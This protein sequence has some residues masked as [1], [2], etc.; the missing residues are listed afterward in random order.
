[1]IHLENFNFQQTES[2]R[3]FSCRVKSSS[4]MPERLTFKAEGKQLL[5]DANPKVDYAAV[6]LLYPAMAFG[7]DIKI[8]GP[9][10]PTLLYQ[11]NHDIQSL[12]IAYQPSLKR[13]S[14]QAS[15]ADIQSANEQPFVATGFS[16]GADT[17]TTLSL[18]SQPEIP[19]ALRVNTLT[20]FS[21]GQGGNDM[22]ARKQL[23][24]KYKNELRDFSEQNGF[25]W[26]TVDSNLASFY[27]DLGVNFQQTHVIRNAAAALLLTDQYKNYLY[28]STYPYQD[29]NSKNDDMGYIEPILLPL[30][31]NE[32]T[33]IHSFGAGLARFQK[34]EIVSRN[35]LA[36]RWLDVCVGPPKK[37]VKNKYPNCSKCWKCQRALVNLEMLGRLD[38]F[39]EVFDIPS[40]KL[41]RDEAVRMILH[42]SLTGKVADRD[43]VRL[44]REHKY[45]YLTKKNILIAYAN[46]LFDVSMMRRKLVQKLRAAKKKSLKLIQ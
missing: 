45:P 8:D 5:K 39:S 6:G 22:E 4:K 2:S 16:G 36:E 35:A 7:E 33:R 32:N 19:S 42:S 10:S 1:M 14:I 41:R 34:M 46:Y 26:H 11:L 18:T 44:M 31:S 21:V 25:N 29:I 9:V 3:E 30:L 38:A 23:I 12:L 20:R 15:N 28:S 37:R 27:S 43:L 24:E 17:F 40:F 13:I